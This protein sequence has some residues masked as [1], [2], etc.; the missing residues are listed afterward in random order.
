LKQSQNLSDYV[1][2]P[3]IFLPTCTE[4]KSAFLLAQQ[5]HRT[6]DI[7]NYCSFGDIHYALARALPPS[8][9]LLKRFLPLL[10]RLHEKAAR[11]VSHGMIPPQHHNQP[12]MF[13]GFRGVDQAV[14]WVSECLTTANL[15]ID[16]GKISGLKSPSA[17]HQ[18]GLHRIFGRTVWVRGDNQNVRVALDIAIYGCREYVSSFTNGSPDRDSGTMM[19]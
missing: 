19:F 13:C 11:S 9:T 4:E 2:S 5:F 15:W 14:I 12:S 10:V 16:A 18:Y 1:K 8:C 7:E 17:H 6:L 3:K